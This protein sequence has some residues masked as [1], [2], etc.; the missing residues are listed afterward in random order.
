M[1]GAEDSIARLV[2][3]VDRMPQ[4][5]ETER[6]AAIADL[7]AAIGRQRDELLLVIEGSA[8]PLQRTLSQLDSTL[9]TGRELS[10]AVNETV[11]SVDDL[12]TKM[13]E[14]SADGEPSERQAIDIADYQRLVDSAVDGVG[15][16]ERSL[17]TID[18]ILGPEVDDTPSR[19]QSGVT[20][21][22]ASS[23]ELVDHVFWRG[24]QFAAV[25]LIGWVIAAVAAK[26]LAARLLNRPGNR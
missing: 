8:E 24:I 16:L 1:E 9:Q 18:R 7:E 14:R 25:V 23:K 2:D 11:R 6:K 19:L 4:D 12:T 22:T 21:A 3:A 17:T 13:Y 15:G 26:L 20:V 5:V 10:S